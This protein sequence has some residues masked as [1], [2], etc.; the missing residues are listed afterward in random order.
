MRIRR[1]EYSCSWCAK[2]EGRPHAKVYARGRGGMS[3]LWLL[4]N[5]CLDRVR[6]ALIHQVYEELGE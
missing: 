1:E 6:D 2:I 3:L 5:N 4:C